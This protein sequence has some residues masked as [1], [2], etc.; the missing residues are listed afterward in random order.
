[1]DS[2]LA[3]REAEPTFSSVGSGVDDVSTNVSKTGTH[4]RLSRAEIALA[5]L[6]EKVCLVPMLLA[7]E[8]KNAT[9]HAEGREILKI[10]ECS[11]DLAPR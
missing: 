8:F 6:N 7:T 2:S 11:I 10:D 3:V 1:M 9:N 5:P 4:R